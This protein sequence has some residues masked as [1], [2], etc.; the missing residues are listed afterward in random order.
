[1]ERSETVSR[2]WSRVYSDATYAIYVRRGTSVF[3]KGEP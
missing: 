2:A 3:S 1:M